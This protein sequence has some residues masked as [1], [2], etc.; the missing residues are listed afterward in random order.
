MST[1]PIPEGH[2][3]VT[4]YLTIKNAVAALEF[5]KEAFGATET[6]RL[7]MPDGRLGMARFVLAIP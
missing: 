6:F 3:T 4:P 7:M 1:K 2:H 5:Y